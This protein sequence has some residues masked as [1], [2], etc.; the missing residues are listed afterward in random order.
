MF[1]ETQA[2]NKQ[3]IAMSNA[4]STV[5][6]SIF[7]SFFFNLAV[8][9]QSK[10]HIYIFLA[11]LGL[12]Y[13]CCKKTEGF[14]FRT[15]YPEFRFA[16]SGFLF[17]PKGMSYSAWQNLL[18]RLCWFLWKRD[19]KKRGVYHVNNRKFLGKK[20]QKNEIAQKPTKTIVNELEA[21]KPVDNENV[22]LELIT[23]LKQFCERKHISQHI[24][25]TIPDRRNQNLITYSKQSIMMSALAIFL[26]RMGSGNE[27]D[28]KSHDDDE[29]YSRTNVAKFIEAPESRVPVIKTIE[30]FLKNLEEESVNKLMIAFF[31]D[32]LQQSKFFQ[33]HPQIMPGDFFLLA[34]DC[35]HT[36]TYDRPHHI[37][38]CGNNDCPCCLQRVY[39]KGGENEKVRWVHNTL[40]F[41]FVFMG[42][43]KIPIY[44]Y[45]IHAKQVVNLESASDDNHKQECELVALKAALPIIRQAFPRM[46]IALL[47][48][49]LYANKPVIQLAQAHRY[50]YIIVRKEACLPLLAKECDEQAMHTNHKKNCVKKCQS[51]HGDWLIEQK[52]AWFNSMYLGDNVSTNVLRFW[53]TR[54]KGEKIESYKCEWLFSWRLSATSCETAARQARARWEVEDLFNTLKNR[55]FNLNHDYSRDPRSCFN[56]QGLALFAFGIFELFRFSE[57]VKQRGD[58]PQSILAEKLL[59]QLLQRPTEELFSKICLMKKIQF[60]Y[61]FVVER[62]LTKEILPNKI[63]YL[64]TG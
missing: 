40:V 47:L 9:D 5:F 3:E 20:T 55:N 19:Y 50:E 7:K 63:A 44:R 36:H 10:N 28:V 33:Q 57:S 41:S 11:F 46:K 6:P 24:E 64:D 35:V 42:G 52:Y 61:H 59:G 4:Y 60:R 26:F 54:T 17:W 30:K 16:H 31:K 25:E 48:D 27:F 58:F 29:K 49:G 13:G 39:N 37:D 8:N 34:A 56:W 53:E 1:F 51:L 32:L 21:C 22:K 43:L 2:H 14:Y 12:M 18:R 38:P 23:I 15:Y 62:I 45:P